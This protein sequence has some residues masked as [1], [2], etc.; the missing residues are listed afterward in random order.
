[1]QPQLEGR[2]VFHGIPVT[3]DFSESAVQEL[4]EHNGAGYK[5]NKE[6]IADHR[7]WKRC[8]DESGGGGDLKLTVVPGNWHVL[9]IWKDDN[10]KIL[11]F[12]YKEL[13]IRRDEQEIKLK[14]LPYPPHR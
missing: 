13:V 7:D 14:P 2:A 4:S 3:D 6:Y 1:L 11:R 12:A 8:D 10:D 9:A 5:D